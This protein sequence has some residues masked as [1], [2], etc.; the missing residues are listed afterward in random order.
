MP[1]FVE[2]PLLSPLMGLFG[3][4][5]SFFGYRL[6]RLLM[7]TAIIFWSF[8]QGQLIFSNFFHYPDP[9]LS[10]AFASLVA[11]VI[12]ISSGFA[13]WLVVLIAGLLIG[14]HLSLL[15][16]GH[17]LISMLMMSIAI[18]IILTVLE[19]PLIVFLTAI[20]GAILTVS[21]LAIIMGWFPL[22]Q[23]SLQELPQRS[24]PQDFLP[25][26]IAPQTLLPQEL[27]PQELPPQ[28]FLPQTLPSQGLQDGDISQNLWQLLG[29][30]PLYAQLV[31]LL[32]IGILIFLGIR[33]QR[34]NLQ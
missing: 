26:D 17:A 28:G 23:L 4:V 22:Q 10:L 13:F 5:V 33:F 16:F 24:L 7:I 20:T 30:M 34:W 6:V 2:Q 11:T 19:R 15:A 3:L 9:R 31:S 21:S 27:P 29:Y 8:R 25:Q 18:A 1:I 32:S 14:Y 12:G